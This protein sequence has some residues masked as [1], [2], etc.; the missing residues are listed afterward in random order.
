MS[1]TPLFGSRLGC[2]VPSTVLM[3]DGD[4]PNTNQRR[5]WLISARTAPLRPMSGPKAPMLF[6][7]PGDYPGGALANA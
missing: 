2:Q 1:Q 7:P 6:W 5:F 4:G 3:V